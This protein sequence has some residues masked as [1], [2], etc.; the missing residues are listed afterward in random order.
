MEVMEA[1]RAGSWRSFGVLKERQYLDSAVGVDLLEV[2]F[3][4]GLTGKVL[5][6]V[7]LLSSSSAI[8]AMGAVQDLSL[9]ILIGGRLHPQSSG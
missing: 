4:F 2:G 1:T 3:S 9:Q 7:L 8:I 6:V 5:A